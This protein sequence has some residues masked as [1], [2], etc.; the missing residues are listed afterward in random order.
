MKQEVLLIAP[1]FDGSGYSET[2]INILTNL[3]KLGKYKIQLEHYHNYNLKVDLPDEKISI[4]NETFSNKIDRS[5][6]ISIQISAPFEWKRY[7]GKNIG[8]GMFETDRIPKEWV[9]ACNGMD[10]IIVPSD[11]NKGTFSKRDISKPIYVVPN[12][13]NHDIMKRE[14][15]SFEIFRDKKYNIL[16]VGTFQYRKGW[17]ILFSSYLKTFKDID[18]VRLIVK[19]FVDSTD[20][21]DTQ[22]NNLKNM[23]NDLRSRFNS[24]KPEICLIRSYLPDHKLARLYRS[25]NLFVLPT[26]GES[27]GYPAFEA[28]ACKVP[29][30]ITGW[31]APAEYLNNDMANH[32]KY[33][34]IGLDSKYM[35]FHPSFVAAG[36]DGDHMWARPD[37][38]HLSSM[39]LDF[40]RGSK[41]PLIK[42]DRAYKFVQKYKW[43]NSVNKISDIIDNLVKN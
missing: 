30:V 19:P 36:N 8:Y 25:A 9:P 16:S 18:K 5:K 40:Y 21:G 17:D 41:I 31:S 6:A 35:S 11:F 37:E 42:V 1:L 13:I 22:I 43:E 38:D 10:A 23:V 29:L 2:G 28:A 39:L 14:T 20:S 15:P 12:G 24:Y 32:I 26:F 3:Y 34:M 4:I 33:S 7:C 27:W